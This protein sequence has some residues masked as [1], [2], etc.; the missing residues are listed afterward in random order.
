MSNWCVKPILALHLIQSFPSDDDRSPS[1]RCWRC[2]T[3]HDLFRPIDSIQSYWFPPMM[4]PTNRWFHP[5]YTY[6][7]IDSVSSKRFL[8]L[9]IDVRSPSSPR[10]RC[11][12]R[13][14]S[15]SVDHN[16]SVQSVSSCRFIRARLLPI[17]LMDSVCCNWTYLLVLTMLSPIDPIIDLI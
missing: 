12:A 15:F 1:S 5:I 9:I 11:S 6:N 10:W 16:Q 2:S 14:L 7:S 3:R 13:A 4:I 17:S 8:L